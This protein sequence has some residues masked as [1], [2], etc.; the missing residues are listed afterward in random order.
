MEKYK[1]KTLSPKE[2]AEDLLSKL[3]L[4]EKMAQVQCYFYM[5]DRPEVFDLMHKNG[6]GEVSCLEFR[7]LETVD[8]AIAL[9]R[10]IQKKII[11]SS[12][13]KIPAIFHMEGLCGLMLKDAVS[14]PT[15]LGRAAS[16]DTELEENIGKIVGR[17]ASAIGISHI[18]APVLDV[19]SNP[20]FGRY[21]ESYGEDPA[22]VSAMGTA[23]AKGIHDPENKGL[24]TEGVAKHFVGSHD[25]TAGIHTTSAYIP[26]RKLR[27]VYAKP[28]QAAI[29]EGELKG[30][31]PCYNSIDGEPVSS[32]DKI[33]NKLLREEMGFEGVTVSDYGAV[34][35]LFSEFKLCESCEDAGYMAMSAG[36]DVEL[37]LPFCYNDK[38]KEK[39][40][41]GEADINVLDRAVLRVLET[42]FRM[43]LFENPFSL[44]GTDFDRLYYS[45]ND[46]AT[47]KKSAAKSLV[48]LKN[49]GI[50][51]IKNA[52]K[53]IAVIGY[54]AG[55]I[56]SMFGGYTHLSMVEGLQADIATMAGVAENGKRER[57]KYPNYPDTNIT[58]EVP[59]ADTFEKIADSM[60][61][62]VKTL[63]EGIKEAFS[64]SEVIY[65]YG[66]DFCGSGTEHFKEA[67]ELAKTCDLTI[68]TLGGK[69]GTG[70]ASSMG[71]NVD[72]TSVNLPP[73]QEIFIE[74]AA[75]VC[76][77]IIGIHIDG[78]PISSDNADKYLNA[79]IEAWSPSEFGT[80]VICETLTGKL[81]P[82]GKLPVTVAY[83][84]GQTPITYNREHGSDYARENAF[85][86]EGYADCSYTPRYLFGFGLSYTD[87][88][89][90]DLEIENNDKIGIKFKVRNTG[91]VYGEEIAQVY[92]EDKIASVVRPNKELA[93][94]VRLDLQ[95]GEEKTAQIT[96]DKSQ[97]AFLDR[98][99][100]WKIEAGKFAVYVGSSSSDNA[101][102]GEFEINEDRYIDGKTRSFYGKAEI[103]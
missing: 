94:S 55:T 96:I 4:D 42:K 69:Y 26:P 20:R 54:H 99:M 21:G 2:R 5:P 82:S 89:Y 34:N 13:H 45:E 41:S 25:N 101:L 19:S 76:K 15:G 70:K 66:Y 28:F 68:L 48:L 63:Y 44:Q 50:L 36:M 64:D 39:F 59:F 103:I 8:E 83:N 14:F 100:K 24:K 87:F 12:P 72:G 22:L 3:S 85:G 57:K 29:T 92:I 93:G 53:R 9:Q 27:E 79:L 11:D 10:S 1:D 86:V 16:F 35:N 56:R 51:P 91:A 95:P 81:N 90:S 7:G 18:L 49:D 30:I 61:P 23:Y 67:L 43:G 38:L 73:C 74:K 60:Y 71:E 37:Q 58:N 88:S 40:A 62:N 33:M 75:E 84:A 46:K 102:V 77:N 17:Q 32:S 47:A 65:S 98:E 78:R 80:E 52:A 31:M 97:L 6:V